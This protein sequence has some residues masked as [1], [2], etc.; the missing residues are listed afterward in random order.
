MEKVVYIDEWDGFDENGL[1]DEDIERVNYVID[2]YLE[3]GKH[4]VRVVLEDD[5]TTV[6]VDDSG[7]YDE[8]PVCCRNCSGNY[9]ECTASCSLFDD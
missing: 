7:D 8:V 1:T 9:P 2:L 3:K 6:T 5:A 4:L